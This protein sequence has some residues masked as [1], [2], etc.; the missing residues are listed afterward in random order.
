MVPNRGPSILQFVLLC[1]SLVQVNAWGLQPKPVPPSEVIGFSSKEINDKLSSV[2]Q[3]MESTDSSVDFGLSDADL[4]CISLS[5]G[6]AQEFIQFG[7]LSQNDAVE[8]KAFCD[9]SSIRYDVYVSR[10]LSS[11]SDRLQEMGE[12]LRS[13]TKFK[14]LLYKERVDRTLYLHIFS[15]LFSILAMLPVYLPLHKHFFAPKA[16][17]EKEVPALRYLHKMLDLH[18]A[19]PI[20]RK[21]ACEYVTTHCA[22]FRIPEDP[23]VRDSFLTT[24]AG[25][26]WQSLKLEVD[27]SYDSTDPRVNQRHLFLAA[28]FVYP[29]YQFIFRSSLPKSMLNNYGGSQELLTELK[30]TANL[31]LAKRLLHYQVSVI[32]VFMYSLVVLIPWKARLLEECYSVTPIVVL[33][34]LGVGYI[35]FGA[36]HSLSNLEVVELVAS[37]SLGATR[38]CII[39]IIYGI[40]LILRRFFTS[41]KTFLDLKDIHLI[42]I[43]MFILVMASDLVSAVLM[44]FFGFCMLSFA[45]YEWWVFFVE[46]LELRHLRQHKQ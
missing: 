8:I 29:L 22:P 18:G 46:C 14:S 6:L 2:R 32:V 24:L 36:F 34:S 28:F 37:R 40:P 12:L 9:L 27:L 5:R 10:T 23:S 38:F 25:P 20:M 42:G 44:F 45:V 17:P 7:M 31:L 35:I 41:K 33:T 3:E 19:D 11:I 30:L 13:R 16:A 1:L 43:S 26:N 39:S 21:F 15:L 4:R